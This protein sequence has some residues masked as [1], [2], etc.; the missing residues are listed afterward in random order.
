MGNFYPKYKLGKDNHELTGEIEHPQITEAPARP[1]KEDT[2]KILKRE[3]TSNG[4]DERA[5]ICLLKKRETV[6]E[7]DSKP[8]FDTSEMFKFDKFDGS[9]IMEIFLHAKRYS[10]GEKVFETEDPYWA[11]ENFRF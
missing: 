6:N 1:L 9:K 10:F 11:T 2:N 8:D 4:N 3:E 7:L 5:E